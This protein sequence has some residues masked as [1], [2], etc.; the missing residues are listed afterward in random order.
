MIVKQE[1]QVKNGWAFLGELWP[2]TSRSTS[3]KG[4]Q[5]IFL[6]WVEDAKVKQEEGGPCDL[7]LWCDAGSMVSQLWPIGQKLYENQL[8]LLLHCWSYFGWWQKRCHPISESLCLTG[9]C[10][11]LMLLTALRH[12]LRRGLVEGSLKRIL[13][14]LH[15][16]WLEKSYMINKKYK[17]LQLDLSI[18]L[19][20]YLQQQQQ[21]HKRISRRKMMM[22]LLVLFLRRKIHRPRQGQMIWR[23]NEK[24]PMLHC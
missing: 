15:W 10:W 3:N 13:M 1:V 16:L 2:R 5:A 24:M 21:Q 9:N 18:L 6:D 12:S 8:G 4:H 20:I 14:I 17:T 22:W 19:L 23:R 7:G 11:R